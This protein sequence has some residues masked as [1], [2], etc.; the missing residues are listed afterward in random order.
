MVFFRPAPTAAEIAASP[1]PTA[2]IVWVVVDAILEVFFL[3]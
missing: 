1:N 2:V 3:W